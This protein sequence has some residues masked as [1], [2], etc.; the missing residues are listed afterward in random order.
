MNNLIKRSRIVFFHLYHHNLG[1]HTK[2]MSFC[3][4]GPSSFLS[5]TESVGIILFCAWRD[6]DVVILGVNPL[7]ILTLFQKAINLLLTSHHRYAN[8]L[9]CH[10]LWWRNFVQRTLLRLLLT[11]PDNWTT[12]SIH[13][14]PGE[15]G[16]GGGKSHAQPEQDEIAEIFDR[17]QSD[18]L[19]C[20]HVRSFCFIY[21]LFIYKKV[22]L[23]TP[24]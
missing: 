16:G 22:Y 17:V 5:R 4:Q 21:I 6:M 24:S 11:S 1:F 2:W 3:W 13:Q 23:W 20:G 10:Q 12:W 15:G 18:R 14:H 8:K 7:Y 19:L 9:P